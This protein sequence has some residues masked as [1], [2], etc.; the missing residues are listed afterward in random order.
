MAE[1][2]ERTGSFLEGF[3]AFLRSAAS[4]SPERLQ[5]MR[6]SA[7]DR[8]ASTGFP[9]KRDEE[10]KY[11]NISPVLERVFAPVITS[12]GNGVARRDVDRFTFGAVA[13]HTLV[14]IDGHFSRELSTLHPLHDGVIIG[15][16]AETIDRQFEAIE[17]YL[18]RVTPHDTDAFTALN[19]AF[20]RDG[21]FVFVP[22]AVAIESPVHL[23]YVA[24]GGTGAHMVH[25]R[26]LIVAR[27]NSAVTVVESFV[28]I[29]DGV[30]FTNPVTEIVM[31]PHA[32]V[33]H[34]KLQD[35][36]PD[37]YHV[38]SIHSR[39]GRDSVYTSICVSL[40]AALSRHNIVSTLDGKGAECTLNG[41]FTATGTRHVD[42]HTTI[43]H[44]QPNCSSRE[45]YKGILDGRSHGVFNG[46][47]IVRPDAQKSDARQ[48][49]KNLLL[50]GRARI[51]TKPQL[52]IF[53]N[54]VKCTHGAT[55]GR[56]EA[57]S[58]F[59]MRSRGIGEQTA[60]AILTKAFA[61]E[62]VDFIKPDPIRAHLDSVLH[63]QI[64]HMG[65]AMIPGGA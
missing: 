11:T 28:R 42:V 34:Y 43:D 26:N 14:F 33:E 5:A 23:L 38:G 10:W 45:V 61:S 59:Y 2:A 31:G 25:P 46:K 9:S 65:E 4:R 18:A 54:D 52:E 56:L 8:L 53:A 36:S 22:D 41:L 29:S 50:D 35:E 16:L 49:N 62:I 48:T 20:L 44:L 7:I 6:R 57:E 21:G 13:W 24:T 27:E 39:Q 47:I 30:C 32:S 19:T 51:N 58:L 12:Q 3:D 15:S 60:R 40:G 63:E 1:I 64:E 37:A 17:P 55:V